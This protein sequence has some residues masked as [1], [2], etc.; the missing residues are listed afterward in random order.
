MGLTWP[1]AAA[2]E[3][4]PLNEDTLLGVVGVDGVDGVVVTD[5][6]NG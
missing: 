5:V 1:I 3:V 6:A 2:A 4:L